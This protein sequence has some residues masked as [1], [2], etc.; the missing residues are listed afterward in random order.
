MSFDTG[1]ELAVRALKADFL[2]CRQW[3]LL[4]SHGASADAAQRLVQQGRAWRQRLAA[5]RDHVHTNFELFDARRVSSLIGMPTRALDETLLHRIW[6]GGALPDGARQAICQWGAALEEVDGGWSSVLWVW[7]AAQLAEDPL[8]RPGPGNDQGCIGRYT[9]GGR[10]LDVHSLATLIRQCVPALAQRLARW[11]AAG[12]YVNLSDYLRILVLREHG[13]VYLDADTMPYRSATVFLARPEVPDYVG[14][15]SVDGQVTARH[16][17]WLNLVRDEN[18]LL[19]ARRG[20]AAVRE[21]ADEMA[22]ALGTLSPFGTPDPRLLQQATYYRWRR[23][24]G[25]T[26]LSWHE[27]TQGYGVLADP[28]PEA[29]VAGVRGM[30][31]R[32]DADT[33]APQPLSP[34]EAQAYERSVA[35][36]AERDWRLAHPLELERVVE[37]AWVT[38]VAPMAYAPQLRAQSPGCNYYSFLCDDPHLERVNALFA[39]Y[40]L[41]RNG[42]RIAQGGFWQP[43]RGACAGTLPV[44]R[45]R[46]L[47]A[48]E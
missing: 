29:V 6:M 28:R 44:P 15:D 19:V 10:D 40:L 35:R 24:A 3:E 9:I 38:E 30:R 1:Y 26:L 8:F 43:M 4:C 14:F 2:A 31:L 22:A 47:F 46:E 12:C 39:A 21:L 36:L 20:D 11:H 7:D 17:S 48:H 37:V 5:L 23:Q 41:A 16:V 27:M 45:R 25:S 13:G 34:A 33:G 42:E 18:G 32:M